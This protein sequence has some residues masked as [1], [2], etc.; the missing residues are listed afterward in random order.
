MGH[1]GQDDVAPGPGAREQRS[2]QRPRPGHGLRLRTARD[3]AVRVAMEVAV[4]GDEL[5]QG[6]EQ[7]LRALGDGAQVGRDVFLDEPESPSRRQH[8]STSRTTAPIR[9]AAQRL[10]GDDRVER[11]VVERHAR[12][13]ALDPR[14]ADAAA[15][16][17]NSSNAASRRP[18]AARRGRRAPCRAGTREVG[19]GADADLEHSQAAARH[20][21][22][23]AATALCSPGCSR[24]QMPTSSAPYAPTLPADDCERDSA[25]APRGRAPREHRA[26]RRRVDA[27]SSYRELAS[28]FCRTCPT[29]GSAREL[30]LSY[31]MRCC[32]FSAR[33]RGEGCNMRGTR[34][35]PRRPPPRARG[36]ALGATA[37]IRGPDRDPPPIPAAAA[38][39]DRGRHARR[40]RTAPAATCSRTRCRTSS[41]RTSTMT[42]T[43]TTTTTTA[44]TSTD[45]HDHPRAR[46]PRRA[47]PPPRRARA[48]RPRAP[49]RHDHDR[50][51]RVGLGVMSGFMFFICEKF[52]RADGRRRRP[53]HDHARPRPRP[54]PTAREPWRGAR[55]RPR[56]RRPRRRRRPEPKLHTPVGA[57]ATNLAADFPHNFTDGI[58]IGAPSSP[59]RAR[60]RDDV[61]VPCTRSHEVGDRDP[62]RTA[63]RAARRPR[64]AVHRGRAFA[65]RVRARGR[66][67][68]RGG[69]EGFVSFTSGGLYVAAGV[70]SGMTPRPPLSPPQGTSRLSRA[71]CSCSRTTTRRAS[72][73]PFA[74]RALCAQASAIRGVPVAELEEHESAR[75]AGRGGGGGGG[76][77]R[78]VEARCGI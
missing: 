8:S 58:A 12:R 5:L 28:A 43:T 6:I 27:P 61:S 13:V 19:R 51:T 24:R 1:I 25:G 60:D 66:A 49:R 4:A 37:L 35:P 63:S 59:G 7:Q 23:I 76:G 38:Q 20:G 10:D 44:S 71:C 46:P 36:G 52:V 31:T 32:R 47:R 50:G 26:A 16:A 73:R 14:E 21:A 11:A 77:A 15:P 78:W 64:A 48:R 29:G 62:T 65:G 74:R 75:P 69:G 45:E 40:G 17:R 72:C 54:R 41:R 53:A 67:R 33:R 70:G 55:P 34:Q 39:G 30:Y 56:R 18:G 3:H 57:A 42:T 22:H 9:D 68:E 2:R